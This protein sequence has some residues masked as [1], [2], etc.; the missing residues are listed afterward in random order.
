M[1]LDGVFWIF[2]G[3]GEDKVLDTSEK[4]VVSS[5]GRWKVYHGPKMPMGLIGA[6]A[7]PLNSQEVIVAG[8]FSTKLDDYTD[9]ILVLSLDNN[10]W[11]TKTSLRL[12][13]GPRIDPGCA[14][15]NLVSGKKVLVAGGWNNFASKTT[16]VSHDGGYFEP[17]THGLNKAKPLPEGLRSSPLA[18]LNDTPFLVGGVICTG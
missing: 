1:A 17:V 7:A 2:G 14:S 8:G 4:L 5:S 12:K 11:T 15:V 3:I 16:E 18:D 9:S 6:C 10:E 13:S